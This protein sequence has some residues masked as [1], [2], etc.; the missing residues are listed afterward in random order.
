MFG[1]H[2]SGNESVEMNMNTPTLTL[3]AALMLG[4]ATFAYAQR[5]GGGFGPP[6]QGPSQ[7]MERGP[8]NDAPG[9][10]GLSRG[11]GPRG[12]GPGAGE[13]L[14]RRSE[15]PNPAVRD[16]PPSAEP[17]EAVRE[18][19]PGPRDTKGTEARQ[20]KP[21]DR[22][23]RN[24]RG[25]I[26]RTAGDGKAKP[27]GDISEPK[28]TKQESTKQEKSA[29]ERMKNDQRGRDSAARD[30]R[31]G[32]EPG[33]AKSKDAA[34]SGPARDAPSSKSADRERTAPADAAKKAEA[35]GD[36][37]PLDEVKK[38]DLA[39]DRKERVSTVFRDRHDVKRRT[40]VDVNISIGARLPSAW[41]YAPV[42]VEVVE[43][44]PEYRGYYYTYVDDT[45]VITDPDSY[46]VVAVLP[47]TGGGATYAAGGGSGGGVCS[48]SL[49][50]TDDE[51]DLLLRS[52]Q[53]T[54]EVAVSDIRVGWSVPR[55][56]E[57]RRFPEPVLD[58][59]SELAPCR[60]FI[61]DDQIAIVDPKEEEVV[62]L[63]A[64]Q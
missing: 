49:S 55:D 60:Y 3:A 38:V 34:D 47:V 20:D 52:I 41:D 62:L 21:Q 22:A 59:A 9:G 15:G 36:R 40:D 23:G 27:K 42:P 43:V 28:S 45:Y 24:E 48:T 11:D 26:D 56:I 61:A 10:A 5:D 18:D 37:K 44:V 53:L 46:E 54:D 35:A 6:S 31:R 19:S 50:L 4:G 33:K 13:R 12:D 25:G 51:R 39:G 7:G 1:F 17:R 30:E 57:L 8:G 64:Q 29:N 63:V 32:N 2:G 58:R 14:E 16:A